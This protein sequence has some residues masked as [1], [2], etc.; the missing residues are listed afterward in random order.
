MATEQGAAPP[1]SAL[2]DLESPDGS[3]ADEFTRQ[4]PEALQITFAP[5][6]RAMVLAAIER[7]RR[8]CVSMV[9]RGIFYHRERA[10]SFESA[11]LRALNANDER[12]AASLGAQRMVEASAAGV[13]MSMRRA[14][15]KLPGACATCGGTKLVPLAVAAPD[16]SPA[17][18][19]CPACAQPQGEPT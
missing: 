17:M 14:I 4:L 19:P 7:E 8:R 18:G 15:E 6:V 13:L 16:G 2:D 9:L 11:I 1:K 12:A 5:A 10:D 3:V